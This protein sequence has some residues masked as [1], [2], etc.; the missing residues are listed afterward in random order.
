MTY[1]KPEA[2]PNQSFDPVQTVIQMGW[3]AAQQQDWLSVNNY[4]KQLPQSEKGKEKKFV[5]NQKEW[6]MAFDL[7]ISMLQK[8]DFQHKWS[9]IKILPWFGADIIPTLTTLVKD[10]TTEADVRWFICQT[11]GNFNNEA[12]ILTLVELLCSTDDQELVEIAGK[13]LTK[14]GDDAIEALEGLLNKPQHRLLAVQS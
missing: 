1:I 7:A 6:Q 12:V 10:T 13:T 14:I 11:L 8:A 4:L 3:A 5:L 2:A 9:I